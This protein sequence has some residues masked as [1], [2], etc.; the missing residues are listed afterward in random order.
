[1]WEKSR[2]MKRALCLVFVA[3]AAL[4]AAPAAHARLA[5]LAVNCGSGKYKPKQIVFACADAGSMVVELRW[6]SWG[7][8]VA[9]ARGRYRWNDCRPACAGGTIRYVR[10]RVRL[11]RPK[12]CAG[13]S[14]RYYQRAVVSRADGRRFA[15]KL[16]CPWS[17]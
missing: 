15:V 5:V 7:G 4:L 12:P 10:A 14:R 1:M 11:E 6:S 16:G 8:D 3:A 2:S 13:K 17:I 9:R